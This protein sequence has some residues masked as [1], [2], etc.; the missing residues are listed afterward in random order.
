[1][2]FKPIYFFLALF[3]GFLFIYLYKNEYRVIYKNK[4]CNGNFCMNI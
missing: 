2:E 4:I 3:L 1:M